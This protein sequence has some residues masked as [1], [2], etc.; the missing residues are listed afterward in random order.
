[1]R[2]LNSEELKHVYGAGGS[3][4]PSDGGYSSKYTTDGGLRSKETKPSKEHTKYS[5]GHSKNKTAK[6]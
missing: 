6:Y 4:K 5:N 1:M 2:D 3:G